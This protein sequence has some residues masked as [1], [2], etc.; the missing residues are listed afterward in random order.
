MKNSI[1]SLIDKIN[2]QSIIEI[3]D[4][5]FELYKQELFAQQLYLG[6]IRKLEGSIIITLKE[7]SAQEELHAYT[8][9]T[10]LNKIDIETK[11]FYE[12]IPASKINLPLTDAIRFDVGKEL[13]AT[14]SYQKAIQ[15]SNNDNMKELLGIILNQEISHVERLKRFLN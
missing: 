8:L 12:N 6:Q 1:D 2:E 10:L 14:I 3:K 15:K 9:K 13:D 7:L 5:L 11:D 4:L